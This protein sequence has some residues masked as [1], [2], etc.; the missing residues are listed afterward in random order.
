MVCVFSLLFSR[1]VVFEEYIIKNIIYREKSTF[2]KVEQNHI[3]P[4]KN[5]VTH[6]IDAQGRPLP[7]PY[8]V[9]VKTRL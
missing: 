8:A 2:E 6:N 7:P 5:S 4:A 1:Y 9:V 3:H